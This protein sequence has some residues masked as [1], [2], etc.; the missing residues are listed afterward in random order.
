MNVPTM[1]TVSEAAAAILDFVINIKIFYYNIVNFKPLQQR[2]EVAMEE[3][4]KAEEE[5]AAAEEKKAN[6]EEKVRD[7]RQTLKEA[8]EE[9]KR[10]EDKCE[11]LE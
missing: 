1:K 2:K 8:Q 5:K 7:L 9:L 6:A 4:R 10:V 3:V 11:E